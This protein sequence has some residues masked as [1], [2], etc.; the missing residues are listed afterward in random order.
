MKVTDLSGSVGTTAARLVL[1]NPSRS[2]LAIY[3]LSGN[4]LF[5]GMQLPV[6]ATQAFVRIQPAAYYEFVERDTPWK[7]AIYLVADGASSSYLCQE[8]ST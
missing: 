2:W 4:N 1:E 8:V 7:G 5:L 6:S 3:N